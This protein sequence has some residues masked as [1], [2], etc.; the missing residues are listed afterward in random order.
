MSQTK[1]KLWLRGQR[2]TQT[3][4]ADMLEMSREHVNRIANGGEPTDAF[5]WRFYSQ[6]GQDAVCAAFDTN[7]NGKAAA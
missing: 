5:L 3:Q 4:L 6:F 7:G 1:F 2:L